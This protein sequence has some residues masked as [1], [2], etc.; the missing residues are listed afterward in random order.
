[1]EGRMTALD[2]LV[3]LSLVTLTIFLFAS[4]MDTT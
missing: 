4:N 1:M 3:G 2:I